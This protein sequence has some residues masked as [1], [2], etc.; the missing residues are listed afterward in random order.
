M[1]PCKWLRKTRFMMKR[2]MYIRLL[3]KRH[4]MLLSTSQLA[5]ALSTSTLWLALGLVVRII[6]ILLRL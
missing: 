6:F 5:V 2:I 3:R 1:D 4:F